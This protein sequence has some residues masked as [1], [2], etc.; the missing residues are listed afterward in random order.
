MTNVTCP[1]CGSSRVHRSRRRDLFEK[2]LSILRGRMHRCRECNARYVRFGGSLVRMTDLQRTRQR[3]F[4]S[5]SIAAAVAMILATIL[6]LSHHSSGSETGRL[7][8]MDCA[9]RRG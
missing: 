7:A 3:L 2:S 9:I 6:W 4:F 1:Q 5:F 8:P